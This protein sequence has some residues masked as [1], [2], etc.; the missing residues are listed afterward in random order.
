MNTQPCLSCGEPT[1]YDARCTQCGALQVT[2]PRPLTPELVLEQKTS[3]LSGLIAKVS[4]LVTGT[5]PEGGSDGRPPVLIALI[6][7]ASAAVA[8]GFELGRHAFEAVLGPDG[9]PLLDLLGKPILR[10]VGPNEGAVTFQV[11]AIVG[12]VYVLGDKLWR[13]LA[14]K[15]RLGRE[16]LMLLMVGA[17]AG[18]VG[19]ASPGCVPAEVIA[20][21]SVLIEHEPSP[22]RVTVIVDGKLV[23][24]TV[25]PMN[26]PLRTIEV[27]TPELEEEPAPTSV[28]PSSQVKPASERALQ[29]VFED[30]CARSRDRP[31]LC[32]EAEPEE[33]SEGSE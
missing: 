12:G 25:G 18:G 16:G 1:P 22:C 11:T 29:T 24:R 19:V 8:L 32:L 31:H 30:A 4:A 7:I 23:H 10:E 2:D 26:C 15:A 28:P 14:T 17:L 20:H 33:A 13:H 3:K 27:E 9:M 5:S 6:A 21:D